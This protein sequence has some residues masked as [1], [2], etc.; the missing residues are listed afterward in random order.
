MV[1]KANPFRLLQGFSSLINGS[2]TPCIQF[3]QDSLFILNADVESIKNLMS[4]ILILE[5]V[6]GLQVNLHK[7]SLNP[8]GRVPNL[9]E[10]TAL[11]GCITA[12][13]PITYLGLP[14]GAKPRPR[15]F[16]L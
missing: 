15:Q 3:A 10:L 6:T 1:A 5:A 12:T 8:V 11:F 7:S 14:L 2:S 9:E 13:L 4:I 16:G